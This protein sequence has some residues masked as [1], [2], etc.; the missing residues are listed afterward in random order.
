MDSRLERQLHFALPQ[1]DLVRR[2]NWPDKS[3]RPLTE[4]RYVTTSHRQK[5]EPARCM[6]A[7]PVLHP[8]SGVS[9]RVL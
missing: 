8:A 4:K 7:A 3:G 6:A 5:A 9:F 2:K 1:F